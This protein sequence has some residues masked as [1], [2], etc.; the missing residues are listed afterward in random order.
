MILS[1]LAG[2]AAAAGGLETIATVAGAAAGIAGGVQQYQGQ[3]KLSEQS[4]QAEALRKQQMQLEARRDYI[5]KIRAMQQGRAAASVRGVSQGADLQDS[6]IQ[7][8]LG[9]AEQYFGYGANALGENVRIGEGLFDLNA[10]MAGTRG[11]IAMG[12]GL[13][14]MGLDIM[15]SGKLFEK[16][17]TTLLNGS[18]GRI[19]PWQTSVIPGVA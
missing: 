14:S 13:N 1:A 5:Q 6:S 17:G 16:V 19:G 4:A 9:Q 7:G 8:S 15:R 10:Q 3:K 18:S 11:D 12:Q 2:I